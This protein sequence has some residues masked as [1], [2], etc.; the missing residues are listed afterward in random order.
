MTIAKKPRRII[1]IRI[2]RYLIGGKTNSKTLLNRKWS[3]RNHHISNI[4][5]FSNANTFIQHFHLRQCAI[6]QLPAEVALPAEICTP[7]GLR[8][9]K[10]RAIGT[11]VLPTSRNSTKHCRK[12]NN[13]HLLLTPILTPA[14]KRGEQ[15]STSPVLYA[16]IIAKLSLVFEY[17]RLYVFH[18]PSIP[19][20]S[21]ASI[22][23][24]RGNR[25][26]EAETRRERR[27]F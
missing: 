26:V 4:V 14:V 21:Y 11:D 5:C 20:F 22:I 18:T 9:G 12:N 24:N 13:T 1:N 27:C 6:L 10:L 15:P 7:Y 2:I 19:D 17:N 25:I 8:R 3:C 16:R 23:L